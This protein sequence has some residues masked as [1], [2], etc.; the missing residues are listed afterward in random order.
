MSLPVLAAV[1]A[2]ATIAANADSRR[3]CAFAQH[4]L[5]LCIFL[6]LGQS[7]QQQSQRTRQ[8]QQQQQQQ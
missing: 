4:E 3:P 1:A 7:K 2:A 5:Q 8:Q 6:Q